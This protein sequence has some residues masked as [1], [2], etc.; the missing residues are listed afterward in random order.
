MYPRQMEINVSVLNMINDFMQQNQITATE[1][2]SALN[3]VSLKIKDAMMQE[4]LAGIQKILKQSEENS[5]EQFDQIQ[6]QLELLE[7]EVVE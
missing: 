3:N 4:Y 6:E 7:E 2:D 1:M 5:K